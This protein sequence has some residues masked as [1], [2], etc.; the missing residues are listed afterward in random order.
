MKSHLKARKK[1]P[2]MLKQGIIPPQGD[3]NYVVRAQADNPKPSTA[4]GP[5]VPH[6]LADEFKRWNP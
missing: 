4:K 5:K 1:S 6:F 3:P 2:S